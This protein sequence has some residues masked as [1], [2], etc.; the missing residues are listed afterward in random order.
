MPAAP[1]VL[2]TVATYAGLTA[3]PNRDA[4][5]AMFEP[6]PDRADLSAELVALQDIEL[7]VALIG[8][9]DRYIRVVTRA[10]FAAHRAAQVGEMPTD[11]D[12]ARYGVA[13]QSYAVRDAA[14]MALDDDRLEGLELW[15]NLSRRLPSPYDAAP[16]FL[17]AWRAYRDGNGALAGI[18]AELALMSDPG[19][20]AA[21]LLTAA[22]RQGIDP[23][24]LPKLRK[25]ASPKRTAERASNA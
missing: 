8:T 10:L 12:V 21:D 23:R 4:L 7:N 24:T 3:L 17:A 11:R 18:A 14:W 5:A 22:L 16:L 25:A 20:S 1:T 15:V 13:L 2:A 9:H 6:L 19:Y